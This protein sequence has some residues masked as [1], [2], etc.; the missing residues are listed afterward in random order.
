[1]NLLK[2]TPRFD[3]EAAAQIA[4]QHFGI[5]ATAQPLPSERD[6]NFLLTT[7]SGEKFVLKIS[8]A[9]EKPAF[10]EAQNAVL[11]HLATRLSFC[12]RLVTSRSG[13]EIVKVRT[14]NGATHLVRMVNYLSGVPLAQVQP[15]TPELLE[16]LGRKLG[17][18]RHALADF[19]HPAVHRDFHWDLENGK[20]IIDEYAGFITDPDLRK[21]VLR[22]RWQ[23]N[24][25][26]ERSVIH[27]DL[28]DYNVLVDPETMT[29]TGLIDFGD[30]VYSCTIGELA[31]A[32]AYVLLDKL[33]PMEAAGDVLHG[34]TSE[35]GLIREEIRELWPLVF[36]RL[37]M[38]VCI[39]AYQL[40][41]QPDNEYLRI[42][43]ES[44]AKLLRESVGQ[45]DEPDQSN[46]GKAI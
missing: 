31:I 12:Q 20:K 26:L 21:L 6:Q 27:G 1:M 36:L 37:G 33:N 41:Q 43:Q 16:D 15:H 45:V 11:K 30:M 7:D 17:E 46:A 42:S 13:K 18:L 8:N 25:E 40:Q 3:I 5:H 4:A 35:C 10:I 28:N 24:P 44:I 34:Y 29:V 9:L 19:D 39:A 22:V 2:N 23:I 32:I 38:S 14:E